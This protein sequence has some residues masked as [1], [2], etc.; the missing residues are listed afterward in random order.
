MLIETEDNPVPSLMTAGQFQGRGG[1]MLRY[2]RFGTEVHPKK[3]T[4][5]LLQGRN[6]CIEKYFETVR[7]LSARGFQ[8]ATFDLRGQGGSQRLLRDPWRGHVASF[9]DYVGDL[10]R[11]MNEVALPD[12]RPPYYLLGH[13]TGALIAL[14]AAPS[15]RNRIERQVLCAPLLRLSEHYPSHRLIGLA[16][17]LLSSLGMGAMAIA[18]RSQLPDFRPFES[19]RLTSDARRYNRN[20]AISAAAP[21]LFIGGPTAS[22]LD[23]FYRASQ[24]VQ[25]SEFIRG[26]QL[27]TLIIAGTADRVVSYRAIENFAARLRSGSLLSLEGAHHEILQEADRFREQFLAAFDAFIPRASQFLPGS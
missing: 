21:N 4:V 3:G 6:E 8:T 23:A 27:P 1:V 18:R 9:F 13:S 25:S 11:F 12:C 19:N 24:L 2:A 7:D 16:S 22:W 26:I 15:M 20:C 10:D 17:S 14:L 5:I